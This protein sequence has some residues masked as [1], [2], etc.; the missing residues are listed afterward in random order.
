M[1]TLPSAST[2]HFARITEV[3]S[4]SSSSENGVPSPVSIVKMAFTSSGVSVSPVPSPAKSARSALIEARSS[5]LMVFLSRCNELAGVAQRAVRLF[6]QEF[7]CKFSAGTLDP[8]LHP[9]A[10]RPTP[11]KSLGLPMSRPSI[12]ASTGTPDFARHER[13]RGAQE[14]RGFIHKKW[15]GAETPARPSAQFPHAHPSPPPA[16]VAAPMGCGSSIEVNA[17]KVA[18]APPPEP[19]KAAA[20]APSASEKAGARTVPDTAAPASSSDGA[21]SAA[22]PSAPAPAAAAAPAPAAIDYDKTQKSMDQRMQEGSLTR[23]RRAGVSAETTKTAIKGKRS[24][25]VDKAIGAQPVISPKSDETKTML[26]AAIDKCLLFD[27][28]T[29]AQRNVVIDVMVAVNVAKGDAVIKQGDELSGGSGDNFYVVGEGTFDIHRVREGETTPE[30][31]QQR[32]AGD[33]FGELALMYNVPRQ[34]TVTCTSDGALLWALRRQTFQEIQHSQALDSIH[35]LNETLQAVEMLSTLDETQFF[36]ARQRVRGGARRG[37]D[38]GDHAGRARRR[39]LRHPAGAGR[40]QVRV[41]AGGADDAQ[42]RRVL[43]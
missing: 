16:G 27:T 26:K 24:S 14:P 11:T 12:T 9:F 36:E 42:R 30:L 38:A 19:A 18:P 35:T 1:L 13:C 40:V 33:I 3:N 37:E 10:A 28:M 17:K 39:L 6:G 34:A 7:C 4:A 15:G 2:G 41:V 23:R 43:W 20:A 8:A 25:S 5:S 31:V 21:G 29:E 22:P 32:A